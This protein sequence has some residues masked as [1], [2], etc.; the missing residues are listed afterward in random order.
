[1]AGAIPIVPELGDEPGAN[2]CDVGLCALDE[3]LKTL[4]E[5]SLFAC[6]DNIDDPS[7][8]DECFL[9]APVIC[10]VK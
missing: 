10:S 4:C 5:A 9:G 6:L 8:D 1:M 2:G 3:D 7:L